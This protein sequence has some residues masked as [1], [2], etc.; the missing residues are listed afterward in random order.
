MLLMTARQALE[1]MARHRGDRIVITTMTAA[2]TWPQLSDSPLDFAYVPSSMGQGPSLGL[3][4]AL[5]QPNRGVIVVNGDG[6]MLMNLG[7]LVTLASHR[8]DVY[9]IVFDNGIY[10]VT[11]GQALAG[12]A[13]R[14][15]F[16][17]LARGS[18]I[19]RV[20]SFATLDEWAGGAEQALTG[21]GPV[22]ICVK[23]E[24]RMG[25]KAPRAPRPMSEQ[26]ARLCQAIGTPVP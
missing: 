10:E 7:A 13:G 16:A 9:L 4:L 14:T 24:G 11:G 26:I 6:C 20:Y 21:P 1:V 8:A 22:F 15:D 23:T 12:A 17:A 19:E 2:S 25:Q 3:G 18:G 5:A